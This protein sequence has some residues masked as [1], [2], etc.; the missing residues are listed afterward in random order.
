MSLVK[1]YSTN[2]FVENMVVPV[3]KKRI[4]ISRL[5]G[6]SNVLI[7]QVTGEVQGTHVTTYK[8]VDSENFV[9]LFTQNIGLTFDLKSSG[10]KAFGVL[11][12]AVQH[13]AIDRDCVTLDA[14]CLSEFLREHK[15]NLSLA[16]FKR[17]LNELERGKI[18]AKHLRKGWYYINPNFCFNGDRVA[19]TTIFEKVSKLKSSDTLDW[20]N[21]LN[22][23]TEEVPS[24]KNN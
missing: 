11:V 9:K 8:K 17:G 23:T 2:P 15:K 4:T 14:L 24:P 1:R 7:N 20:V 13:K 21:Q 19:F 18:I 10:I 5:G 16:T 3:S 6:E 12:W 22:Q